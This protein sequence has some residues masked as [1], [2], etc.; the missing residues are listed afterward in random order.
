MLKK[1][2]LEQNAEIERIGNLVVL[3]CDKSNVKTCLFTG[4]TLKMSILEQNS[5]FVSG[6]VSGYVLG[7]V[8]CCKLE[9]VRAPRRFSLLQTLCARQYEKRTQ[10]A[11]LVGKTCYYPPRHPC[12]CGG[13]QARA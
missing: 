9:L 1:S 11:E 13:A 6:Y 12:D 4:E 8:F 7:Y 2:I 3:R 10:Q 5:E